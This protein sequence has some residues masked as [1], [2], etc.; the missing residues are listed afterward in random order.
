MKFLLLSL[1]TLLVGCGD[2]GTKYTYKEPKDEVPPEE[3]EEPGKKPEEKP[4][5]EKP[6]DP[7][8]PSAEELRVIALSEVV[9][10]CALCHGGSQP[11]PLTNEGE[12]LGKKERVCV[13]VSND[14]MPPGGGLDEETKQAILK[15][16][17]C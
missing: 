8:K 17:E 9:E 12:I 6:E 3:G 15:G 5:E 10:N 16:L 7:A 1:I 11:P 14:T 2:A 4:G 13:R